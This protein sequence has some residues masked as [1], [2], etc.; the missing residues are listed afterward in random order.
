MNL[1]AQSVDFF[2]LHILFLVKTMKKND[3]TKAFFQAK[4]IFEASVLVLSVVHCI[5]VTLCAFSFVFKNL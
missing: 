3:G 5:P 2:D 1:R 4:R